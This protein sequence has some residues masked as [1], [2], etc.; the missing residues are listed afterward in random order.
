MAAAKVLLVNDDEAVRIT[1]AEGL[2]QSGFAVSCATNLVEALTRI[3]SESYDALLTNLHI[4][5]ARDGLTLVSALRYANPSAVILLLSAFPQL[6]AAAQAILLQAD[7]ILVRPMDTPSL[8]DTITHRVAVGPVRNR[9]V[10]SVA[11]ILERTTEAAIAE[12]YGLV[13][14]DS[15]LMSVQMSCDHRCS[16]LPQLFHD[17]VVR[18]GSSTPICGKAS[19]SAHAAVHGINRRKRGYTAAMLVEES[20]ILQVSIFRTLHNNRAEIDFDLLMIGV[21]TIADEVD[22]QLRQAMESFGTGSDRQRRPPW[23]PVCPV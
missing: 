11:A 10:E 4:S 8:V 19:L 3:S 14:M 22:S 9:E 21:A 23:A 6:E 1:L 20:R 16:H 13:L 12:W 18:L 17:L 2:E 7:E 5:R 15:L